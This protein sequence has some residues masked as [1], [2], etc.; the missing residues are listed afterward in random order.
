MANPSSMLRQIKHNLA[1]YENGSRNPVGQAWSLFRLRRAFLLA[2][3]VVHLRRAFSLSLSPDELLLLMTVYVRSIQAAKAFG[4]TDAMVIMKVFVFDLFG[5]IETGF[6]TEPRRYDEGTEEKPGLAHL[7]LLG[8]KGLMVELESQGVCEVSEVFQYAEEVY[9]FCDR[10]H[11]DPDPRN[12]MEVA[13]AKRLIQCLSG[14][15]AAI[16]RAKCHPMP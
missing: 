16:R 12:S 4:F 9:R 10:F 8:G 2:E 3:Q 7:A 14:D 15:S 5:E 1:P 6:Q 13:W 11:D